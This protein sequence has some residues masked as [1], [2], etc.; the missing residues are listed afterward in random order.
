MKNIA[1]TFL[2]HQQ[3]GEAEAF[4]KLLPDLKLKNSYVTCQWLALGRKEERYTRMKRVDKGETK[5]WQNWKVLMAHG[6]SSPTS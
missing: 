1:S 4:Y 6:T 2:S 3:I 5:I